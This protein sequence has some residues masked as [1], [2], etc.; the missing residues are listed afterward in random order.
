MRRYKKRSAM[1]ARRISKCS[2]LAVVLLAANIFALEPLGGQSEPNSTQPSA[3]A[4]REINRIVAETTKKLSSTDLHTILLTPLSGCLRTPQLCNELDGVLREE[5]EKSIP[6]AQFIER[7]AAIKYLAPNGFLGIDAYMGALDGVAFYAGAE[8]VIGEDFQ[9]WNHKCQ[10]HTTLVD[11]RHHYELADLNTPIPCSAIQTKAKLSVLEDDPTG[12]FMI[13][14]VP[15]SQDTSRL[16]MPIQYPSCIRCPNPHYSEFA[17][18]R[19]IQGTVRILV[20]ITEQGNT[21]NAKVLGGVEESLERVS[22]D[23]VSRWKVKPATDG[24]GKPFP[25]RLEAQMNFR[26]AP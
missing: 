18:E 17:R 19:K 1:Q 9:E 10:L 25:A 7:Q 14:G 3:S 20:T 16:A 23:T 5:I 4:G 12:V 22:L 26:M 24:N 15:E 21:Q 8:V 13:V 6:G 2:L 11:A